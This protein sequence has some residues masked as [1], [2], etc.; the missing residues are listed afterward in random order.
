[1]V[2][3]WGQFWGVFV[4]GFEVC[5]VWFVFEL[6]CFVL[7]VVWFF[8]WLLVWV[9]FFDFVVVFDSDGYCVVQVVEV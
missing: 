5:L 8:L 6:I 3:E 7:L 1:M 4:V 2:G 9:G